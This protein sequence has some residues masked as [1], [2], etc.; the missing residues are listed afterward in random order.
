V[1]KSGMSI[2]LKVSR[3]KVTDICQDILATGNVQDFSV[4]EEPIEDIIREIF[5]RQHAV[6]EKELGARI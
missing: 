6:V 1:S 4:E 5:E 2:T 3:E